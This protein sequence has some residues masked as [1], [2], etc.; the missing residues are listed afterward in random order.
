MKE[1]KLP[2][3]VQKSQSSMFLKKFLLAY[4]GLSCPPSMYICQNLIYPS[5][6]AVAKTVPSGDK[7][8]SLTR[9]R[10]GHETICTISAVRNQFHKPR[11]TQHN[12]LRVLLQWILISEKIFSIFNDDHGRKASLKLSAMNT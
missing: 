4:L 12:I 7:A 5:W 1:F 11:I 6:L 3:R 9:C 2:N 8:P 10:D